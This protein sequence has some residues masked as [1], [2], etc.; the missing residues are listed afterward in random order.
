MNKFSPAEEYLRKT[1][2][3]EIL[4]FLKYFL[5][6]Y[7]IQGVRF[8]DLKEVLEEYK[9][10][11]NHDMVIGLVREAQFLNE[12]ADWEFV[13]KFIRKQTTKQLSGDKPQILIQTILN[14]L[15]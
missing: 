1:Y 7:Y 12:K 14:T 6:C 5:D 3:N 4:V 9:K 13:D 15:Q 10:S 8:E 11:E 2:K